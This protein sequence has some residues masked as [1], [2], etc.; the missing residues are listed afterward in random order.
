VVDLRSSG[1]KALKRHLKL[2][3]P[4]RSNRPRRSEVRE[5][6]KWFTLWYNHEKVNRNT[7]TTPA[8]RYGA[9]PRTDP[10]DAMRKLFKL[11]DV[12][13]PRQG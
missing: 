4:G 9:M 3:F 6:I 8:R 1:Q 2:R 12:L 7:G 5:Q 11:E 13:T 10:Y